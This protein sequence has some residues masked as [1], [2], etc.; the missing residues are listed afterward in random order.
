MADDKPKNS[1]PRADALGGF[2]IADMKRPEIRTY[3]KPAKK[4]AA[5]Q[6]E[7]SASAGFPAVESRLEKHTID[8]V[9]D[10]IRPSY[11]KLEAI[12]NDGDRKVRAQAKKAMAAY[13]RT[14]DLFEYLFATKDSIAK[15]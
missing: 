15:R 2:R 14:A 12:A 7:A 5:P 3:T 8:Q 6:P 4:D 13:E 10:E 9:A 1:G 11:E